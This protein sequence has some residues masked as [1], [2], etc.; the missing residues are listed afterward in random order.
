M[1][2]E[3]ASFT[4]RVR[5][6]KA[7]QVEGYEFEEKVGS[8]AVRFGVHKDEGGNWGVTDLRTGLLAGVAKESTRK[9]AI[10][11]FELHSLPKLAELY[12]SERYSK[13]CDEFISIVCPEP[14]DELAKLKS[15]YESVCKD[16]NDATLKVRE[17]EAELERL[18][19]EDAAMPAT[20]ELQSKVDALIAEHE[21][22]G[23]A[24]ETSC[25]IYLSGIEKNSP[26]MEAAKAAGAKFGNH[27]KYG[28]CW[29][30]PR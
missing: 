27:K 24:G 10:Q 14:V 20:N 9:R 26:E 3:K 13:L 25:A 23:I 11:A 17:L 18:K 30:M 22:I 1:N 2:F 28:K 29:Y 21:M 5:G 16:F 19:S 6:N 7:Q 8:E 15:D 4:I 12:D